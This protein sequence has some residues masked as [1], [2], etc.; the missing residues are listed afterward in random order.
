MLYL[1]LGDTWH[2]AAIAIHQGERTA[3]FRCGL[4][5]DL[6]LLHLLAYS[7]VI[8]L[9]SVGPPGIVLPAELDGFLAAEVCLFHLMVVDRGLFCFGFKGF[10]RGPSPTIEAHL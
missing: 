2:L 7:D 3:A 6:H 8:D 10:E 9:C 4:V 5:V 1:L